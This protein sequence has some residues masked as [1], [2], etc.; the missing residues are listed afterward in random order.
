MY[1][2]SMSKSVT[3]PTIFILAAGN[4]FIYNNNMSI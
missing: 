4:H 3:K 1:N 2:C